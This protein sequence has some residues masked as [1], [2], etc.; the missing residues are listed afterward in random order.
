MH[1]N[2]HNETV[3]EFAADFVGFEATWGCFRDIAS[4]ADTSLVTNWPDNPLTKI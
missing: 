1:K 3:D 2:L 4:A